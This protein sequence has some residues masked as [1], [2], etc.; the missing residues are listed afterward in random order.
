M[1]EPIDAEQLPDLN[2]DGISG[3]DVS[4][5]F[6]ALLQDARHETLD[7]LSHISMTAFDL[8]PVELQTE[9]DIHEFSMEEFSL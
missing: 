2:S 8:L 4:T 3:I 6:E 7:G 1:S 9:A 5:E